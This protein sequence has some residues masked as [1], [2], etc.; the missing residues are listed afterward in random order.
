MSR[1]TA[2]RKSKSTKKNSKKS[3]SKII[4]EECQSYLSSK[5]NDV[6]RNAYERNLKRFINFTVSRF[7]VKSKSEINKEHLQA[8]VDFLIKKGLTPSSVHTYVAPCA[9]WLQINLKEI[10]KEKRKVSENI[11]SRSRANKYKYSAQQYDNDIYALVVNFQSKVGIRRSELQNLRLNNLKQDESGYWCVEVEKGKGGKYHLQ[12][13]LPD[14]VEFIKSYFKKTPESTEKLF[15]DSDFS[16][17]MD[18]HKLRALQAQRA[19]RYYYEQLHTGDPEL[20]KAN[21]YRMRGELIKRWNKYNI[22]KRTGMTKRFSVADTFGTYKLRGDN[23]RFAIVNGLST[24]YSRL[25]LY[26]VSLLH[27][28]HYRLSVCMNYLLNV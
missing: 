1:H 4:F 5:K 7:H 17:K 21:E 13:L 19:Y 3:T 25:C 27:L 18:Y 15:K 8:Y 28:S 6:T 22:D 9:G 24:E 11:R 2:R 20:D 23:R 12:R 14:D 16:D 10:S 26:M